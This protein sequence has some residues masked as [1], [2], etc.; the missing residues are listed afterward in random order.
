M[1]REGLPIR[2]DSDAEGDMNGLFAYEALRMIRG[3][4]SL[5]EVALQGG[6]F[7]IQAILPLR[8]HPRREKWH[9]GSIPII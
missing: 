9:Q 4:V 1:H 5:L 2:E 8:F 3:E 6:V 7:Q